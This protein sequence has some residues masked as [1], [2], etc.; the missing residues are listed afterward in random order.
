MSYKS[1]QTEIHERVGLIRIDRPKALNAL[2]ST[3]M[4]ELGQALQVYDADPQVGAIVI[5]GDARA[6]A[7]GADIKEMVDATAAEMLQSEPI[8]R[9][10]LIRE[11]KKPIIAAVSGWCLG[12]GNEL[13][14]SCDM[15]I[16]SE[17]AKFGQPEI[18]IGVIPGA[19]GTQRLTRAVG[20]ALAMEMVLNNRHL[21]AE[22]AHKFGLV[23]RVVPEENFLDEALKLANEIAKRAPLAVR[24]GKEMVN[25]AFESFLADGIADERRSFYF[26]FSTEDQK[27][28]MYAFME[29]REAEWKGI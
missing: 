2:N 28:G 20:K 9:W 6:F 18:N 29:K 26:L 22:E 13:A 5:T 1:I 11:V 8:E 4:E 24:M 10:D 25:Q 23:N 17:T 14:M 7:A 15:I 3:V 12:G 27:E 19:G 16:A 21:D